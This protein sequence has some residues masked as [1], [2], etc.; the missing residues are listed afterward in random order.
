MLLISAWLP[1][2]C[3]VVAG[4]GETA[5]LITLPGPQ[6]TRW[7]DRLIAE[8]DIALFGQQLASLT[9]IGLSSREYAWG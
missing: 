1:A 7:L 6:N 8:R 2:L 5:T 3:L 9:G 4:R